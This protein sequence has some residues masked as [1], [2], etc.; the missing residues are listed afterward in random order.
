MPSTFEN[1]FE[2]TAAGT[3]KIYEQYTNDQGKNVTSCMTTEGL[4]RRRR[5]FSALFHPDFLQCKNYDRSDK[6]SCVDLKGRSTTVV[7][8][9]KATQG[10]ESSYLSVK[11]DISFPGPHQL[12]IEIPKDD[13][14]DR[15]EAKVEQALLENEI[16]FK[17]EDGRG[18]YRIAVFD[19][20]DNAKDWKQKFREWDKQRSTNVQYC[21]NL[22]RVGRYGIC[23]TEDLEYNFGFCSS[24]CRL[25]DPSDSNVQQHALYW[26]MEATYYENQISSNDEKYGK[27]RQLP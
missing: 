26:E 7:K 21:Y 27:F 4:A 24:S 19:D 12:R 6:Y 11:M 9:G 23:E 3:G 14:C 13:E 5:L 22:N 2:V 20:D 18:P 1:D 8:D 25:P 16:G 10:Y 15:L 17:K